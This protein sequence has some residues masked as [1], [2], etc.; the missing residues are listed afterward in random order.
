M[1][2]VENIHFE[3]MTAS[4]GQFLYDG[5]G[6][7]VAYFAYL[8]DNHRPIL[9]RRTH[10]DASWDDIRKHGEHMLTLQKARTARHDSRSRR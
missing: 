5:S 7:I 2:L 9:L 1:Q 6:N 8:A 4:F 3:I 10:P